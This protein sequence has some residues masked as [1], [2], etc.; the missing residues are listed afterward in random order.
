[1]SD[2]ES[3]DPALGLSPQSKRLINQA[4][5]AQN[6]NG[7]GSDSMSNAFAIWYAD[8][9]DGISER[10]STVRSAANSLS[11]EHAQSD[12]PTRQQKSLC[13]KGFG[14]A[15]LAL[16]FIDLVPSPNATFN[17]AH[18]AAFR[19][20]QSDFSRCAELVGTPTGSGTKAAEELYAQVDVTLAVL[21]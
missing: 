19:E 1:M 3:T 17:E 12:G 20:F 13:N 21:P 15:Q 2:F 9:K 8:A 6:V 7:S 4:T 10:I 18:Q 14:A 16:G 5:S 11:A